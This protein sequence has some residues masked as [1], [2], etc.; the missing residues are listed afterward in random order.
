MNVEIVS[1]DFLVYLFFIFK[2]FLSYMEFKEFGERI[3]RKLTRKATNEKYV[4]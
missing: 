2:F 3:I 1:I 4:N